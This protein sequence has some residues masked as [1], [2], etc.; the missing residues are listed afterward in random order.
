[1]RREDSRSLEYQ[2][3]SKYLTLPRSTMHASFN[4]FCALPLLELIG[5]NHD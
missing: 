5:L 2:L 1:M 3:Y 4:V